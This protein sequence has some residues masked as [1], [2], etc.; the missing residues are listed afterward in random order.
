[1]KR[2]MKRFSAGTL[3]K[4]LIFVAVMNTVIFTTTAVLHEAGHALLGVY[5]GCED[6]AI[7]LFDLSS[8]ATYTAMQCVNPPSAAQIVLSSFIFIVPLSLLFLALKGFK[9]RYMGIILLGGNFMG[10]FLDVAAFTTSPIIRYGFVVIGIFLILVGEDMLVTSSIR[11]RT[12]DIH[13]RRE[14]ERREEEEEDED[15]DS[16]GDEEGGTEEDA[17]ETDE[18]DESAGEEADDDTEADER[19]EEDEG[20]DAAEER[21]DGEDDEEDDGTDSKQS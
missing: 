11:E 7:I 14:S 20:A 10:A 18:D 17:D 1:M 2:G 5:L 6:I 9:E 15:D 21:R 3:S 13:E 4:L 8:N 16:E 12:P 19:E